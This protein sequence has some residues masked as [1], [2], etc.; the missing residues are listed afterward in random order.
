[1]RISLIILAF[2]VMTPSFGQ[3]SSSKKSGIEISFVRKRNIGIEQIN[4]KLNKNKKKYS[5]GITLGNK[6]S[7]RRKRK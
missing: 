3:F 1:M 2:I 4:K 7:L 6:I 5:K